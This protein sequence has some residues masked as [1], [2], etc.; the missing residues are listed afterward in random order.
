MDIAKNVMDGISDNVTGATVD[1][2]ATALEW[3]C[4]GTGKKTLII[5]N[6]D[7]ANALK[8]KVTTYA[9]KDGTGYEEVAETEITAGNLAQVLL[10]YAYAKV[11]VEIKSSVGSTPAD[12]QI[13]FV[14]NR[15]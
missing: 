6:T 3:F 10:E 2:Y 13:D 12:Y 14:G 11:K 9:N 8:Y 4:L 15:I 7:G 1:A 5:A